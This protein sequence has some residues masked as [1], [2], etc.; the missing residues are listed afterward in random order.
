MNGPPGLPPQLKRFFTRLLFDP[1]GYRN[2]VVTEHGLLNA[3]HPDRYKRFI[4][5]GGDTPHTAL[6]SPLFNIQQADGVP[7]HGWTDDFLR[8]SNNWIDIVEP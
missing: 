7:L 5:N 1:L 8:K 4:V 3:A 2:L 6:Q